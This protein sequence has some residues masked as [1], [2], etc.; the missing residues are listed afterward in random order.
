MKTIATTINIL[1]FTGMFF[2]S[3]VAMKQV[4]SA[5][6][7]CML[8]IFAGQ[9]PTGAHPATKRVW[10]LGYEMSDMV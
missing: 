6:M 10:Q 2:D 4:A 3:A 9:L 8:Q 7:R 5:Y 1:A